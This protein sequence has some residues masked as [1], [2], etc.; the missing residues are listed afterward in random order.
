MR[1]GLLVA[2]QSGWDSCREEHQE[3]LLR[4]QIA[5]AAAATDDDDAHGGEQY[6]GRRDRW[7]DEH[8]QPASWRLS[9]RDG[10]GSVVWPDFL[11]RVEDLGRRIAAHHDSA[12]ADVVV[13]Y[14]A[15]SNGAA[16]VE[17]HAELVQAA[18]D[19][20]VAARGGRSWRRCQQA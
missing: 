2:W 4:L 6:S 5:R 14:A 18:E 9:G 8:L 13:L 15:R 17:R 11:G 3:E 10:G 20:E 1:M 19:G 16:R 12:V 7:V